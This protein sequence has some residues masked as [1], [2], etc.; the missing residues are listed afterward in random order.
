M[1]KG[2]CIEGTKRN[3]LFLHDGLI[4]AITIFRLLPSDLYKEKYTLNGNILAVG[5]F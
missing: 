3:H 2:V 1:H 5:N 4:E